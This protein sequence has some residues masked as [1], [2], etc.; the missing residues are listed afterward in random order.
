MGEITFDPPIRLNRDYTPSL[1]AAIT[2]RQEASVVIANL[3]TC[4]IHW[5]GVVACLETSTDMMKLR[6]ALATALDR[7]G[8]LSEDDVDA[9][10][11]YRIPLPPRGH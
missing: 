5:C 8:F 2:T 4:G 1:P 10:G 9:R 6:L 7:Y 3:P 11:R